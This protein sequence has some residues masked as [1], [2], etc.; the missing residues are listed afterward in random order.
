MRIGSTSHFDLVAI[1]QTI[2]KGVVA[3]TVGTKDPL[4]SDECS[5][6]GRSKLYPMLSASK[7]I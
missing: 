3:S 2:C 1:P 7:I 4:S 6:S 5:S